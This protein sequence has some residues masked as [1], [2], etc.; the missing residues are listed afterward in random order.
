MIVMHVQVVSEFD[1]AIRMMKFAVNHPWKFRSFQF[2]FLTGLLKF[3]VLLIIELSNVYV[4][5][6]NSS[7]L[8]DI[9]ANFV[10][11]L[12]LVEFDNFFYMMRSSD[13]ITSMMIEENFSYIFCWETTTSYDAA[14]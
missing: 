8:F 3:S 10:I 4:V 2:A 1:E 14:A 6:A 9:I 13:E 5:L 7:S 11:M 12:V